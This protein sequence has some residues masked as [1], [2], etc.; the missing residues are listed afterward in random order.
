MQFKQTLVRLLPLLFPCTA[1]SQTTYFPQD[2]RENLLIERLEIKAQT[3]TVFNFSKTKPYSRKSFIPEIERYYVSGAYPR[4]IEVPVPDSL[5][6]LINPIELPSNPGLSKVDQYNIGIALMN[7]PEWATQDFSSKKRFL[8]GFY[9][10]PA[11]LYEV[12][13]KDFFLAIN[14]V[15]QYVVGKEKNNDEN[16]FLNTRGATIRGRI[17]DKIGFDAYITDNQERDPLYVQRVVS[18]H[19]AVPGEG[20]Y[21]NFKTTGY[22]Y[23]DARGSVTFG[24]TKYI[25]VQFGYDKNFIGN[26]YRSLFLSDVS[27]PNLFLKLNTRIWKFNYENLFMELNSANRLNADKL[28]PKKYAAMH[29][30]DMGITKWLNVGLFEGIIFGRENHFEFSYLNP[31]IFYRSIEQQNGS[32]DNAVVGLDMKAN[33]AKRF[34]FYGQFLLDEFNLTELKRGS[35]WWANKFGYQLGAKYIDAFN[36]HNLDLQIESNRVRP[37]TYSHTDSV[38]NYT[39]YNQTLAHPLGANFQEF[40][41][42]ARYQP[43]PRWL[44]QARAIY[45]VQ[46]RDSSNIS[47]GSNIFLPN[48]PPYRNMDFGYEVG[49]GLRTRVG[50]AS[51]LLSYELKPNLFVETNAV[52]R[53]ERADATAS[54]AAKTTNT[55]VIYFGIRWNMWRRE[56]NF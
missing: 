18:A 56:F 55:S 2:A 49:S 12:N 41:G 27:A 8:K 31:I 40:I 53:K 43:A 20:F 50:I 24:V 39:H 51:F 9:T 4:F 25:D 16:I 22:D 3:D 6:K 17:A 19:K 13:V 14:P 10:S 37:F 26:G 54:T 23:F 28:L 11:Y 7:S 52:F 48:V 34:Q 32:Y 45:Y 38:A 47:Y 1:F 5:R 30:L 46:G 33:V 42:T 29:H 35:G 44:V 15:F 21:K 36:I